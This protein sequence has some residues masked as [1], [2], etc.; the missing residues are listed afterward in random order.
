MELSR[1]GVDLARR[2][3]GERRE[4]G[5]QKAL[6]EGVK[7][8]LDVFGRLGEGGLVGTLDDGVVD[9]LPPD[10]ADA[11]LGFDG[12]GRCG[13]QEADGAEVGVGVVAAEPRG[14]REA[15]DGVAELGELGRL[16]AVDEL[17]GVGLELAH[18]ED[19]RV[20]FRPGHGRVVRARGALECCGVGEAGRWGG[21][22]S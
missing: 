18:G 3:G 13:D 1:S 14:Q 22:E 8:V 10:V 6:D 21:K 20:V 7:G 9:V 11:E 2:Q 4:A 5:G 19:G 12:G 17:V 16:G 15:P